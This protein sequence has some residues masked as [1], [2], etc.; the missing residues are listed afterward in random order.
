MTTRITLLSLAVLA[1]PSACKV[2]DP[3]PVTEP[4][5]DDFA[6]GDI[7]RNYKPTS[8]AYAIT[9]GVLNV[10]GAYNHPLWLR[11]KLPDDLV[12]ELDVWGKTPDGDLKVEIFGDGES[13]AHNKGAYTSSGYVLCMGGW[14][15][16]KSFIA[17]GNE[18]GK[19]M[20][21]REEP[22][23]CQVRSITGRSCAR[24]AA[25]TGTSTTC[26]RPS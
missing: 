23:S 19:D 5:T 24:A 25:W 10:K 22:R 17:R 7:G 18:H 3:P 20:S 14:N 26:R 16:S 6:R 12:V 21:T 15:N 13:H 8:E 9:D 11:K 1:L 4:W 2:Q